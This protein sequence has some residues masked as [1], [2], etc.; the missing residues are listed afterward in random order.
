MNYLNILK[1]MENSKAPLVSVIVT[2]YNRKELLKETLDSI[3][4]QTFTNF[5]LIVV[6]DGSTDNTE[7]IIQKI[8]DTRIIYI[9]I[10]NWGGPARPRNIGIKKAKGEYIAFCDDD[11][12]WVEEKLDKQLSE[13]ANGELI[14]VGS[15]SKVFGYTEIHRTKRRH[16]ITNKILNFNDILNGNAAPLSS[17]LVRKSSLQFNES[18]DYLFV[19]DFLFQIELV[20]L[21]GILIIDEPLIGYRQHKNNSS[22]I[23][24]NSLNKINALKKLYKENLINPLTYNSL[25][26]NS[27]YNTGIKILRNGGKESALMFYKSIDLYN[28]KLIPI[29]LLLILISLFPDKIIYQVLHLYYRNNDK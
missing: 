27:Y 10:D 23:K 24:K 25:I 29:K 4:N 26:K 15:T 12:L 1:I 17:L 2:T 9:K 3:L 18:Q 19:E 21:G 7:E 6:D 13:F 8:K 5:E 16:I 28:I 14:A 22:S 11:D 20:L